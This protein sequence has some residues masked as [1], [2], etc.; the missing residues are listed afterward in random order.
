MKRIVAAI[1]FFSPL[2]VFSQYSIHDIKKLKI[3]RM[4]QLSKTGEGTE[5]HKTEHFYDRQGNDTAWYI[6]GSLQSRAVFSFDSKGRPVKRIKYN[7]EGSE[8]ETGIYS[9]QP[10][11]GWK[12]TNSDKTYGMKDYAWYDKKGNM[13][14]SQSPDGAQRIYSYDA[15]GNLSSVKTK[16]GPNG[17]TNVSLKYT[18]NS[19]GQLIKEV[20][21]GEYKWTTDYTYDAKGLLIR[22]TT[23]IPEMDP[24]D[25]EYS[26][27]FWK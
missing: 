9:Y 5:P 10:D 6:G 3:N 26:Y 27:E 1:L 11:G 21:D 4:T 7:G 19:K 13:L 20:S 17:G 15:K 18:Y 16:A 14:K 24:T 23:I 25:A 8:S 2:V 22:S 12:I